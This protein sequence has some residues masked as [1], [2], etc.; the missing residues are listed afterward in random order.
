MCGIAGIF[1]QGNI[2]HMT[3]ILTHRGPDDFGYFEGENV[4]L[5]IRR[6]SVIDLETGHQPIHNEDKSIWVV[7]NG[8]IFNYPEIT[9]ELK[10]RGHRFYTRSDTEVIVHAYEEF[11]VDCLKLFIGMFAFA[12]WDDNKKIM[13][14]ARDR[15]GEKPFYYYCKDNRFLFASEI[16]SILTQVDTGPDFDEDFWVFE[17]T[18][19]DKTLFK[20]IYSLPPASY[21][22][23]DGRRVTVRQY[24]DI[25]P[26]SD[27]FHNES[28]Y[29]EK[30]RWLIEDA[31]QLRL[32]SDVPVGV[33]LSGGLDSAIIACIA[34]P[35]KVFSCRYA[36]G[37]KYDEHYYADLLAKHTGAEHFTVEPTSQ[38]FRKEFPGIIL[39]E[40]RLAR[41]PILRNYKPLMRFF[42]SED[43]FS[44]P[45]KRYFDMIK[46]CEPR[47]GMVYEAF[48][49]CFNK[50]SSLIDRMCLCDL[51]LTLP[52]LL[53]MN[54]RAAAAFGLENR[55]PF[56]DHRI[57]ELAFQL[58]P[59][60]KIKDYR[61]KYI[62]RQAVRGLVPDEIIDRE[63]KKGLA[64]PI[65]AWFENELRQWVDSL[66]SD[67]R[68]RGIICP[69][70]GSNRGEC[71]RSDYTSISIE[72]WHK[73]FFDKER[74]FGPYPMGTDTTK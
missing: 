58:P 37:E 68:K 7:F 9:K 30:L 39:E 56:L 22:L 49:L 74:E 61:T 32:R 29:A 38:D 6:L 8:E 52:S 35:D 42:W 53:T 44:E 57:V 40:D 43:M 21:L 14:M 51:E 62:L 47:S 15:I 64:V 11:G 1:G 54:D 45:E 59:E 18:V 2:R 13:F 25:P 5:G 60:M 70:T 20:D 65:S 34:K 4:Q 46:R 10:K 23:F 66:K 71:D 55:S 12:V 36:Y 31:V 17:T 63:D 16:K 26:E 28:Y 73:L 50:R 33:Y 69:R 48:K 3:Q 27:H 72:M 67:L 19:S 24:W 41:V